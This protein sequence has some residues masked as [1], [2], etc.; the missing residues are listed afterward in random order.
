MQNEHLSGL[1]LAQVGAPNSLLV[2]DEAG[3]VGRWAPRPTPC[4][5][6]R[7]AGPAERD[8]RSRPVYATV[9][10]FQ[11]V[12]L[13]LLHC[14]QSTSEVMITHPRTLLGYSAAAPTRQGGQGTAC[15]W[16]GASQVALAMRVRGAP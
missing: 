11:T 1:V 14:P 4:R 9:L 10:M 16:A 6:T 12:E 7:L 5:R 3:S 8:P 15:N 13:S 2:A